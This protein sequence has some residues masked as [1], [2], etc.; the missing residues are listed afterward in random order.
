MTEFRKKP[1]VIEAFQMHYHPG[2]NYDGIGKDQWAHWFREA[3]FKDEQ[4]PGWVYLHANGLW[5]I[6]T[7][8]GIMEISP[9]DYVIRGIKGE[10]YPCKEDVFLATYEAV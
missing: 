9:G 10:L 1:I 3:V 7:L 5:V 6:W 8:D 2:S 4:T